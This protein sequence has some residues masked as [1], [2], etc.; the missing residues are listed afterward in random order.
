MSW[1][2]PLRVGGAVVPLVGG[3]YVVRDTLFVPL[4]WLAEFIPRMFTEGYRYDPLAARF[5]EARLAPVV[6]RMSR[7]SVPSSTGHRPATQ[8]E[9]ANGFRLHHKV[10]VDAGHGGVDEGNPGVYLP[11]GIKEKHVALSIA[12]DVQRALD[13]MGIEVVMTRTTDTLINLFER[14]PLCRTDCDL[15]V[16]IHVNSMPRSDRGRTRG[17]MT[18]FIG[19]EVTEEADRV[20]RMENAALRYQSDYVS[21]VE[22]DPLAFIMKD[23]QTNEFLRES[24]QAAEFIQREGTRVHPGGDRK[25][26]QSRGFV[27]LRTAT[28]PAVL[29]E[30]GFATNRSDGAF[31]GTRDGQRNLGAAIARG[32]VEYLHHY[33]RKLLGGSP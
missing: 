9:T 4:Q 13:S 23:L 17:M 20:A 31:L 7:G 1:C 33:E 18:Y 27:V 19:D 29:V 22:N 12:K 21:D 8:R 11:R 3:A 6:T 26:K 32:I 28:R 16:S 30:T 2:P 15:F 5:E 10:V 14:A 24:A 25:A